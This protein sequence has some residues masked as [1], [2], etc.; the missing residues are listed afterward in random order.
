MEATTL[1]MNRTGGSVSPLGTK[2][3]T[4]AAN[5]LSPPQPIDTSA[6]EAERI[7]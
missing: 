4:E 5:A 2:A 1:G 6:M 3:M 7:A